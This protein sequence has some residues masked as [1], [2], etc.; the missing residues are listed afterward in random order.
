MKKI[1]YLVLFI[2]AIFML[3]SNVEAKTA[4][5]V[6]SYNNAGNTMAGQGAVTIRI[7][8]DNSA[9][10]TITL[11]DGKV[12]N[13]S[14]GVSNWSSV[15]S[16]YQSTG[17]CPYYVN[18]TYGGIGGASVWA[19]YDQ[20]ASSSA[21]TSQKSTILQSTTLAEDTKDYSQI[22]SAKKELG[23]YANSCNSW[24]STTFSIDDCRN[25][26]KITTRFSECK[27]DTASKI[28]L[29][30][31]YITTAKRYV[32]QYLITNSDKE[33][34][35]VIKNCEKA[36]GNLENFEKALDKISTN[37]Y[38][39]EMGTDIKSSISDEELKDNPYYQSYL[40]NSNN[41]SNN[42]IGFLQICNPQENPRIVAAFKLGG[43]LI[44]IAKIIVPIIL[45]VMGMLDISKA[46]ADNKDG[47]LKKSFI[48]FAQRS[49]AGILVFFAPSIIL[50]LFKVIDGFDDVES[51]YETCIVCLTDPGQCPNVNFTG[52]N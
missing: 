19:Y 21:A 7:Y 18:M 27:S 41:S 26:E 23:S 32:S 15:V 14:E 49:V 34:D 40:S 47:A 20:N 46:V 6:C 11:A 4:S 12:V 36:K 42:D 52:G 9:D 13:N 22:D 2:F 16:S 3:I 28:S 37:E 10:A 45:I 50:G 24:A 17:H 51:K 35:Q 25:S 31:S 5:K 48:T 33:Y 8:T 39:D 29:A 1:N 44:T 30:N 43:I 38:N